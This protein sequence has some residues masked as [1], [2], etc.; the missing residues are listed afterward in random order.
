MDAT[1]FTN[2]AISAAVAVAIGLIGLVLSS[3]AV[4]LVHR[5]LDN[6]LEKSLVGLLSSLVRLL[7]LGAAAKI[8]VDQTGATGLLVMVVTA[9]TAAFAL[10][11]ERIAGDMVAGLNLFAMR[12]Y[13]V[14]D[15]VKINDVGGYVTAIT[16][17]HTELRVYE[18]DRIIIPNSAIVGA[19]IVN[20]S[21]VPGL[22][23]SAKYE[24]TGP[25]DRPLVLETL[26][27]IG[28]AYPYQFPAGD[29]AREIWSYMY[30]VT[31]TE[32]GTNSIYFLDVF[33]PEE[34]YRY[35]LDLLAEVRMA[36]EK[37]YPPR[38]GA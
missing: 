16:L 24:I 23:L 2:F 31:E 13:K 19:T 8:V 10:G 20:H 11:S 33:A 21:A 27:Q 38:G 29:P 37:I 1:A 34:Y 25:H 22:L 28:E 12:Y 36:L 17:T 18:R 3:I 35:E 7:V 14:G 32:W 6:R 5:L 26:K 4:R 15:R 30:E 9:L